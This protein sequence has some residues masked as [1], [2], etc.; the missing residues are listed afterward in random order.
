MQEE[1][2]KKW[3]INADI[4]KMSNRDVIIM[5]KKKIKLSNL[6]S[7]HFRFIRKLEYGVENSAVISGKKDII[8][9]EIITFLKKFR[10]MVPYSEKYVDT[11]MEKTYLYYLRK[12][13]TPACEIDRALECSV[14]IVGC[15]GVGATVANHLA[16]SGVA[17]FILIDD[18]YVQLSNLNRQIPYNLHNVGEKKTSALAKHL[19]QLGEVSIQ[20]IDKRINC[21]QDYLDALESRRV[22]FIVCAIDSPPILSRIWTTEYA[23]SREI[24]IIFGGVGIEEGYYGPLLYKKDQYAEYITYLN[25]VSR[26]IIVNENKPTSGSISWSNGVVAAYMAGAVIKHLFGHNVDHLIKQKEIDLNI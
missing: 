10:L 16:R 23:S 4:I 14:A 5:G 13:E 3:I 21:Y 7:S 9:E 2:T 25:E 15:G 24:P 8:L 11:I 17:N 22:D 6:S 19:T 12:Y 20:C 26:K 1:L 18:D